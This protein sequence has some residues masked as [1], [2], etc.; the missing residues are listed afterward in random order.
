MN[1]SS[2]SLS[3]SLSEEKEQQREGGFY[4]STL[5]GAKE[6]KEKNYWYPTPHAPKHET[7]SSSV[8]MP[9][10]KGKKKDSS[11]EDEVLVVG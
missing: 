2:L 6:E 10:K 4:K 7:R 1:K 8:A 5:V 3:L 11:S 9:K